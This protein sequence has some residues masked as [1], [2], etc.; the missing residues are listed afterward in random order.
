MYKE[1]LLEKGLGF[2]GL[3]AVGGSLPQ[4]PIKTGLSL[5]RGVAIAAT[6]VATTGFQARGAHGL[7]GLA[8]VGQQPV[9][10][11]RRVGLGYLHN[12]PQGTAMRSPRASA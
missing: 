11:L 12:G 5:G 4:L 3:G 2:F 1:G 9:A 6:G 8:H 10:D 7:G